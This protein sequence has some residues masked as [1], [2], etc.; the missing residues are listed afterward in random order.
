MKRS[1]VNKYRSAKAFRRDVSKTKLVNV[2]GVQ[3]GGIRL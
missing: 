3:R 2:K 1:P